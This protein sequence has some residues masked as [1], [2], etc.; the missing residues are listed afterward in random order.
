MNFDRGRKPMDMFPPINLEE[1][2]RK[3][4]VLKEEKQKEAPSETTDDIMPEKD[5]IG[6]FSECVDELLA[7]LEGVTEE[8]IR[9]MEDKIGQNPSRG[10]DEKIY[11][12]LAN[13]MSRDELDEFFN[14][15]KMKNL[16]GYSS[17]THGIRNAMH[18]LSI[19]TG[20]E[21]YKSFMD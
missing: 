19:K 1:L 4:F 18:I 21:K 16:P 8:D 15:A 17:V 6:N 3:E 13:K 11:L 5:L 2:K 20:E 10:G 9:A 7:L 12:A 14:G